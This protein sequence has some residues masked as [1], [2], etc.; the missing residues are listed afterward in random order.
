MT[1]YFHLLQQ[2]SHMILQQ[3]QFILLWLKNSINFYPFWVSH[4]QVEVFCFLH[5]WCPLSTIF[6]WRQSTISSTTTA[7]LAVVDRGSM[8]GQ[9]V[10]A[11]MSGG[12]TSLMS[13]SCSACKMFVSFVVV[14]SFGD[15]KLWNMGEHGTSSPMLVL[16]NHIS[17][18]KRCH[19]S[20]NNFR[21]GQLL[22]LNPTWRV[23]V[24]MTGSWNQRGWPT[25]LWCIWIPPSI[26]TQALWKS[27]PQ[28]QINLSSF[29]TL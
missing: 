20:L 29:S 4:F 7:I 8:S 11:M 1:F 13:R 22:P 21:R 19:C 5:F 3:I 6:P 17:G 25:L 23:A 27:K 24:W 18:E 15:L 26:R 2:V 28:N 16:A 12:N 9:T 10:V 14:W